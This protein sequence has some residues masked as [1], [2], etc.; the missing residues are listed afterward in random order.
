MMCVK[1][2][3]FCVSLSF[4]EDDKEWYECLKCVNCGFY[5]WGNRYVYEHNR[6]NKNYSKMVVFK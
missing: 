1:C 6:D 5:S 4:S 2:N 3:G